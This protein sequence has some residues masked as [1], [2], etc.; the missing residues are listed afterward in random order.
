MTNE[1][2]EDLFYYFGGLKTQLDAGDWPGFA[3]GMK[4]EGG[5]EN[6]SIRCASL[7]TERRKEKS[8]KHMPLSFSALKPIP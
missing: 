2:R 7:L 1:R 3:G 5:A 8:M 4:I 6:K